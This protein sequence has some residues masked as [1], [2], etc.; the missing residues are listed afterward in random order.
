MYTRYLKEVLL[1]K[2]EIYTELIKKSPLPVQRDIMKKLDTNPEITP[3]P[4]NRLNELLINETYQNEIGFTELKSSGWLVAMK[5]EM[6]NVTKEMIDWWFWWQAQESE[7]YQVWFPG[8]HTSIEYSK[9]DTSYFNEPFN[10][11]KENLQF[12]KEKIGSLHGTISIQFVSPSKFGFDEN[13][14]KDNGI[15]T[16][17][18]GNVGLLRGALEHTKMCHIFKKSEKG[19]YIISRFWI[20][21][22]ITFINKPKNS[23]LNKLADCKLL[24]RK[25][26]NKKRGYD[27][28]VHCNEEYRHLAEILPYLY[29]LYK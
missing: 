15:E 20:G 9:K 24:K 18:C 13:L 25:V 22:E 27:M 6:P 23:F 3:L 2:K 4:F 26:A 29:K 8:Y 11:F 16:I 10:G 14:L 7:R 5:S 1:M 19:L 21:D 12:P 17:V 28:A